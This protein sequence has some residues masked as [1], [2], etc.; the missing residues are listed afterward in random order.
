ML[1]SSLIV[2]AHGILWHTYT[3]TSAPRTLFVAVTVHQYVCMFVSRVVYVAPVVPMSQSPGIRQGGLASSDVI[4]SAVQL[5]T[6]SSY[7][8]GRG[9]WDM[10]GYAIQWIFFLGGGRVQ[11]IYGLFI[12]KMMPYIR[13]HCVFVTQVNPIF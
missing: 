7:E 5:H 10:P 3:M 4:W 9:R 13:N 11:N 12:C 6:P 8:G 2:H 1:N